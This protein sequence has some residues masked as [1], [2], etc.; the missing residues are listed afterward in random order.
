MSDGKF[1]TIG[2]DHPINK[3]A[4]ALTENAFEL[5]AEFGISR[6]DLCVAMANAIGKIMAEAAAPMADP[7]PGVTMQRRGKGL[8]RS[9]ALGRMDDLRVVM[10][11]AYDL[12]GA[13]GQA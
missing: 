6:F 5:S 13:E 4:T 10:E 2:P 7:P 8:P 12:H 9:A 11:A 3:I 1:D